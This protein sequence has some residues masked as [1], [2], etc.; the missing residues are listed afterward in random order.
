MDAIPATLQTTYAN[1][2][3]AHLNQPA[4]DFDG[5][6]FML[7]RAGRK[8]WYANQRGMGAAAPK[9]RYLG[10][11]TEEMRERIEQMRQQKK[12]QA[13]FR[14]N[15]ARMIAQLRAGGIPGLDRQSGTALRALTRSGVFRLGGTLVG[16]HAFRH[17]DLELGVVL[18]GADASDSD[19]TETEDIDIASFERPST[20][21]DDNAEPDLAEALADLDFKPA[22]SLDTRRPTSWRH[23]RTSYA[24]DFLTPS[25][26]ERE[27]PRR[28][29]ALNLWAQGLHF[30]DFLIKDPMP[31]VSLY[32]EGLLVQVPRPERYAVHKLII[33]QRRHAGLKTKARKDVEQA[34]R[35]IWA[36]ADINAH[37]LRT[38]IAEADA[39]GP[40]WREALDEALKVSFVS[41]RPVHNLE[42]DEVRLWGK[43]LGSERLFSITGEALRRHF[44]ADD[45]NRFDV[46]QA[47]RSR[48]E[49]LFQASFRRAPSLHTVIGHKEATALL[50]ANPS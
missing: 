16:T 11:D 50:A 34:S 46:A 45:L 7:E 22:N 8:Y 3:Q 1:L 28:L 42:N 39:R 47:N 9:Q 19:L 41:P 23:A 25:F 24:I 49:A 37:E 26:E 29:E 17:Y 6:P 48:I 14:E 2:L 27:G 31:A 21:I 30:L 4:F 10:P 13:A 32:M 38:A 12:D 33:S 44:G 18:S 35:I 36:M 15:C 5:S 40:K 20:A 43:V